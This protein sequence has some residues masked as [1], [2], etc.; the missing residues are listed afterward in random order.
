MIDALSNE[1]LLGAIRALIKKS[2][3]IEADLLVHLGELDERS[4]YLAQ[5]FSSMFVYCV[6]GLGFSE[7]A[8]Y[9]RIG[10]AR[11]GR[12]WPALIEAVRSGKI[13]LAGMRLL[14]PHLTEENHGDLLAQA[15]GKSKRQIDQMIA[16]LFPKPPVPAT[17]RKVPSLP[18]PALSMLPR[19]ALC[20]PPELELSMPAGHTPPSFARRVQPQ[21]AIR[22]L[23]ED[24]YKIQFT[25]SRAFREKLKQTQE[26][27]RHR[28]PDGDLAAVFEAALD[29]L[30]HQVKKERF[31]VGRKA[32][33][34]PQTGPV[35]PKV[36][37]HRPT[38]HI[39]DQS[40]APFTNAMA[41]A[42][43]S[44]TKTAADAA[45]L[46]RSSSTTSM[47]SRVRKSIPLNESGSS[48][49]RTTSMLRSS[50]MDAPSCS[51]RGS[52]Y[53]Y[54]RDWTVPMIQLVPGRVLSAGSFKQDPQKDRAL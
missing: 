54:Q 10:V 50:C 24:A 23:A 11:A 6:E 38:R 40:S 20:V 48:A 22:P 52:R 28:I 36:E 30:I 29:L 2:G 13:H 25:A 19:V 41:G 5:S 42:A 33:P 45:R 53:R 26:L 35:A 14:V 49:V 15:A 9:N 18:S 31:A 37:G 51:A 43:P 47:A 7:D 17:I 12:R 32:R 4:L 39:P 44:L 3:C 27:L 8:T 46:A 1:E 21:P 34:A 16:R